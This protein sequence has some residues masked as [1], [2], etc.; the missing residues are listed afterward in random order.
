[1]TTEQGKYSATNEND[2]TVG[3]V[4]DELFAAYFEGTAALSSLI[5]VLRAMDEKATVRA[6]DVANLLYPCL[7]EIDFR[8]NVVRSRNSA[9]RS[10][11]AESPVALSMDGPGNPGH[12]EYH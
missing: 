9:P 5:D 1:M 11:G 7:R 8:L 12:G 3:Q 6:R 2:V 10:D 4:L